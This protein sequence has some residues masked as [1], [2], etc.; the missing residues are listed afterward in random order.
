MWKVSFI[1]IVKE[2]NI[3]VFEEMDLLI[4]WLG[5]ELKR[6]VSSIRGFNI[7]DLVKGFYCIWECLEECYGRFEMIEFVLKNKFNKFFKIIMKD[8]KML[9]DLFDILIEI[10]LVKE[11]E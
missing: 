2:L 11:N 9:Y 7:N 10:E 5:L 8:L 4:K 6:F 1:S 3:F